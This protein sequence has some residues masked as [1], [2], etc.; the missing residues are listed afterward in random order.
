MLTTCRICLAAAIFVGSCLSAWAQN[1][2]IP[3]ARLIERMLKKRSLESIVLNGDAVVVGE[4]ARFG[5][6]P[7]YCDVTLSGVE[8]LRGEHVEEMNVRIPDGL[9]GMP[10]LALSKLLAK[11]DLPEVQWKGHLLLVAVDR[12]AGRGKEDWTASGAV[13]LSEEN[14]ALW[15]AEGSQL[16]NADEILRAARATIRKFP[17]MTR[18]QTFPSTVPVEGDSTGSVELLLEVP[19]DERLE[20]RSQLYARSDKTS[21]RAE[22]VRG[23]R[24]FKTETNIRLVKSL[25]QDPDFKFVATNSTNDRMLKL[26]PV[27]DAATETLRYWGMK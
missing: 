3:S 14:V 1:L 27:R 16:A 25:L 22:G 9:A 23:L 26:Y 18:M 17:G 5:A 20:M 12:A 19:V 15:R 4:V 8:T 21:Q 10:R 13:D 7:A 24:F 11:D 2:E 6:D